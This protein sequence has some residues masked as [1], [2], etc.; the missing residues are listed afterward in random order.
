MYKWTLGQLGKQSQFKAN[1]KPIQSQFKAN[2]KP[3]KANI[4]QKQTQYEPKQTQFQRQKSG[5]G[6]NDRIKQS[7][8]PYT[9]VANI[10]RLTAELFG[11]TM[12]ELT[13]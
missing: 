6:A 1:S 13:F 8:I 9:N 3:I 11:S 7:A 4:M 5:W 12:F 2:S 10:C